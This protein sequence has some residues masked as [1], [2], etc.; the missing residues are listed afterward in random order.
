VSVEGSRDDQTRKSQTVG[1]LL[2]SL[3]SRSESRRSNIGT[4]VVVHNNADNDVNDSDDALAKD[5]S[6]LV[7][8]GLSHLSSDREEDRSSTVGENESSDGGHSFSEGRGVEELVVGLPDAVLGGEVGAVL[9]TNGDGDY[10]DCISLEMFTGSVMMGLTGCD[11][12]DE[13][14]PSKPTDFIKRSNRSGNK[15]H[16]TRNGHKD[17][18]TSTMH[19]QTVQS[20][21]DTKHSRTRNANRKKRVRNTIKLASKA[22]KYKPSCV[23]DAVDLRVSLLEPSDDVV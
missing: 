16:N 15:S 23:I 3:S 4:A 11:E 7:V 21:R 9:N 13:T 5:Q 1:D 14:N 18:G 12:G 20:N 17:R 2:D 8:L 19:T 22:S 6:L 10:K